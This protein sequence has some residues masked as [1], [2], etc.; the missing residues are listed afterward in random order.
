M[1]PKP[2]YLLFAFLLPCL[3][4]AQNITVTKKTASKTIKANTD[5]CFSTEAEVTVETPVFNHKTNVQIKDKLNS[6]VKEF[7]KGLSTSS[8]GCNIYVGYSGE[9]ISDT[10]VSIQFSVGENGWNATDTESYTT[11]LNLIVSEDSSEVISAPS[12]LQKKNLPS[13]ESSC[14]KNLKSALEASGIKYSLDDIPQKC[15]LEETS[16]YAFTEKGT[17]FFVRV[18]YR[19]VAFDLEVIVPYKDLSPSKLLF[20]IN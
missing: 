7:M 6:K 10:L 4:S 8:N 2:L 9:Y 5:Y 13:I 3:A 1:N 14:R 16:I 15:Y 17:K 19:D 11:T 20:G 12:K 18:S